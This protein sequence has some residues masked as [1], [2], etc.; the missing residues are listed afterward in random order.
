MYGL[1]E[2]FDGSFFVRRVLELVSYTSN[3][4]FLAFDNDVAITIESSYEYTINELHVE[5]QAIPV[6]SSALM[7]LIGHS[8][9]SV[10]AERDGTLTLQFDEGHVLRCFDD[11]PNYESYS[12]ARGN[13]R[14]FV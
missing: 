12:I 2:G 9:E 8:V 4:L 14:I 11:L 5:R 6:A 7:Q 13:D 3:T 10:E 1:P